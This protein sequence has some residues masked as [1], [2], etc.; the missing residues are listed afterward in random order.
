MAEDAIERDL[1]VQFPGPVFLPE[2]IVGGNPAT[3]PVLA[4][5]EDQAG[6]AR[7]LARRQGA[8]HLDA[9]QGG[10]QEQRPFDLGEGEAPLADQPLGAAANR[11]RDIFWAPHID[12]LDEAV[13]DGEPHRGPIAQ[14]LWRNDD[15][16]EDEPGARIG[17][18]QIAGQLVEL[19]H[20]GA[21]AFEGAD[22]G[23]RGRRQFRPAILDDDLVHLDGEV[24]T[25]CR[26]RCG[27]GGRERRRG[28]GRPIRLQCWRC[29][30]AGCRALGLGGA[31]GAEGGQGD[32]SSQP[33]PHHGLTTTRPPSSIPPRP[34]PTPPSTWR[35]G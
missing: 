13:D 27:T 19:I 9:R 14:G 12:G 24:L 11:T 15:A 30:L 1:A 33:E 21:A 31:T 5:F 4:N 18:F 25:L 10:G 22:Q 28:G 17:R 20:R 8:A 6:S 7:L 26:R 23:G 29:D 2:P 34:H 16:D 3:D 32:Q 35:K